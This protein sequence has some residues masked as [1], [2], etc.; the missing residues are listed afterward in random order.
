M[1]DLRINTAPA[2]LKIPP[3]IGR[4]RLFPAAT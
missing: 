3:M 2:P 4:F 1:N